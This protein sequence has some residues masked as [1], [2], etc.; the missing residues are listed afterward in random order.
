MSNLPVSTSS[1]V[2]RL[3][4]L[5][6]RYLQQPLHPPP[7][8]DCCGS[9]TEAGFLC[10]LS[11][12]P[13]RS[14]KA[15]GSSSAGSGRETKPFEENCHDDAGKRARQPTA[16][17]M[18]DSLLPALGLLLWMETSMQD[19]PINWNLPQMWIFCFG[20]CSARAG[21]CLSAVRGAIFHHI[22]ILIA[23]NTWVCL[24]EHLL[25]Q[26]SKQIPQTRMQTTN[27]SSWGEQKWPCTLP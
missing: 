27:S 12:S 14:R 17:P 8:P 19:R 9:I 3:T 20:S 7:S 6:V 4:A 13:A 5:D 2:L 16:S 22:T 21:V 18:Q 15:P 23:I 11:A 25:K 24:K 1:L 10:L 26:T